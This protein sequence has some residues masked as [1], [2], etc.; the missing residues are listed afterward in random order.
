MCDEHML[1]LLV[2][3]VSSTNRLLCRQK[4]DL[5]SKCLSNA[6]LVEYVVL[7]DLDDEGIRLAREH[8]ASCKEC[9]A[10]YDDMEA[11]ALEFP[12]REPEGEW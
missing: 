4:E 2:I 11:K 12:P 5:M 3:Y 9:E 6:E 1:A 10:R 7:D 8:I